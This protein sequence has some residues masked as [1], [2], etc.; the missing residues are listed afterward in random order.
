MRVAVLASAAL[1]T[2]FSASERVGGPHRA[3]SDAGAAAA[4]SFEGFE[5][6]WPRW[7]KQFKSGPG[8]GDFSYFPG[9]PTSVC[10]QPPSAHPTLPPDPTPRVH[11]GAHFPTSPP[12][13]G[14]TGRL[15]AW[16]QTVRPTR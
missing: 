6:L 12:V 16:P 4:S 8:V 2:A 10:A 7:M 3:G 5:A 1:G 14:L 15:C 9:H 11:P 13:S